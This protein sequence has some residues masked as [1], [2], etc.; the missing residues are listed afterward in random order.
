MKYIA[1][2]RYLAGGY[3][4]HSTWPD[5]EAEDKGAA[6]RYARAAYAKHFPEKKILEIYI[7]ES[8]E[9]DWEEYRNSPRIFLVEREWDIKNAPAIIARGIERCARALEESYEQNKGV[10]MSWFGVVWA[11]TQI[12]LTL[13]LILPLLLRLL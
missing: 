3:V 8:D 10:R 5:I 6:E 2:I 1:V 7:Y 9:N 11:V 4:S 13:L 12:L